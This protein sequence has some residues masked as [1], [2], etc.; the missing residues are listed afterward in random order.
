MSDNAAKSINVPCPVLQEMYATGHAVDLAGK[1][2]P[3]ESAIQPDFSEA[4][5]RLIKARRPKRVLEIGMAYGASSLAILTALSEF[6][7]GGELISIDPAQSN[8]WHS[9]GVHNVARAGFADAHRLIEKPD[10]LGLPELLQEKVSIDLGYIDGW[11]TF[12]HALLDFFYIDK[13]L[14]VGGVV[15]FNDCGWKSVFKAIR[16]VETHRDY[17]EIDVGLAPR[18]PGGLVASLAK[19]FIGRNGS[20][21]YFEKRKEWQSAHNFY[22]PF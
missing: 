12:D 11:H 17:R 20:D 21:R 16:F 14:P 18:Y 13:L 9:I 22:A 7:E 2:H 4:L 10:Y 15:G 1:K 5:Y 19:R 6:G 3:I 8:G